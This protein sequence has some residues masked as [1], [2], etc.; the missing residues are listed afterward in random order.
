MGFAMV[1]ISLQ[2]R[3]FTPPSCVTCPTKCIIFQCC[4]SCLHTC[5]FLYGS[6]QLS[7]LWISLPEHWEIFV[8]CNNVQYKQLVVGCSGLREVTSSILIN[9][10]L[11]WGV[12]IN[13]K[14]IPSTCKIL[15]GFPSALS[16]PALVAKLLQCVHQ[17]AT[18][19]GNPEEDLFILFRSEEVR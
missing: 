2:F 9:S 13:G 6:S 11:S 5:L 12:H 17:A 15:S 10:D 4:Y 1:K 8:G 16:S 3:D 7:P 19:P 18:C 14:N